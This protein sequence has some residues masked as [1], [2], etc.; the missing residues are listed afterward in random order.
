MDTQ[1]LYRPEEAA[2][3][4]SLSRATVYELLSSG[5]LPSI[6]IGRSRRITRAALESFV[7]G[8]AGSAGAA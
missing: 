6:K 1:L 8:L 7:A 5:S 4:L 2:E 3:V